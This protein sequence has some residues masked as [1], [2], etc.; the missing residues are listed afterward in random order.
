MSGAAAAPDELRPRA[1]PQAR[2][3]QGSPRADGEFAPD[4]A[5]TATGAESSDHGEDGSGSG[6]CLDSG[7]EDLGGGGGRARRRIR[8]GRKGRSGGADSARRAA[9]RVRRARKDSEDEFQD[10]VL[11]CILLIIV[12]FFIVGL[13]ILFT[14]YS[15]S[16]V[17][18]TPGDTRV[19]A[20]RRRGPQAK[21]TTREISVDIATIY[22][23]G[24][25]KITYQRQ[26]VC[27]SRDMSQ[28]PGCSGRKIEVQVQ[29]DFF[30]GYVH[31]TYYCRYLVEKTIDI[32]AGFVGDRPIIV[33]DAGDIM[34]NAYPG[35]LVVHVRPRSHR[36]FRRDG[37]DIHMDLEISL[38]ES[39][40]GFSRE[41]KHIDGHP[42][43]VEASGVTPPSA[44]VVV[45]GEGMPLRKSRWSSQTHG[46]LLVHISVQ[47]PRQKR[48]PRLAVEEL[49][50]VFKD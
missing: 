45:N 4:S 39:L 22:S 24:S 11:F 15:S 19:H 26:V 47:F 9:E 14:S 8:K 5:Q 29:R 30:S 41:V 50:R 28:C 34:P 27:G 31:R 1:R 49:K 44:V 21:A 20:R 23:G 12:G 36:K 10:C 40:L 48:L 17:Q 42:V 16:D 32:P 18:D 33:S 25:R 3:P 37:D 13:V 6:S 35:D 38:R 7:D 43:K 2:S 46:R